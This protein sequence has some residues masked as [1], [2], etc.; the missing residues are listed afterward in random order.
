MFANMVITPEM[1]S[2]GAW[3]RYKKAWPQLPVY[4][5]EELAHKATTPRFDA[6]VPIEQRATLLVLILGSEI[7][8]LK[9]YLIRLS[10]LHGIKEVHP[11]SGD[12]VHAAD[13]AGR[14]SAY[15][16]Y[17]VAVVGVTNLH[18]FSQT[19]DRY[20]RTERLVGITVDVFEPTT[21]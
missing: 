7:N 1:I 8:F 4:D 19:I 6:E 17:K 20:I 12:L 21:N 3:D 9:Q 13:L 10:T 14:L 2:K 18:D 11:D 5:L 16:G 15:S